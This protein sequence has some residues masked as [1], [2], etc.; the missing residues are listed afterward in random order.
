M[1]N[2]LR[3]ELVP[4]TQSVEL[5]ANQGPEPSAHQNGVSEIGVHLIPGV[6]HRGVDVTHVE[7]IRS[8]QHSLGHE[9]TAA[10]H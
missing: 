2:T 1:I 9:V 8:C 7:L 6:A 10:D 4:L 3:T 5:T